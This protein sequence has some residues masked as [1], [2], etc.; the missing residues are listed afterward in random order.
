[1]TKEIN[2]KQEKE[3]KKVGVL[4]LDGGDLRFL[5]PGGIMKGHLREL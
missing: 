4:T 3:K 2:K 5:A 1:M